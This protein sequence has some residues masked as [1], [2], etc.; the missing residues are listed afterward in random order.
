MSAVQSHLPTPTIVVGSRRVLVVDDDE[1]QLRAVER[2]SR[3][4]KQLEVSVADNAI[5]ALLRIGT[6]RPDIIVLDVFMPGLDGI[7]ACR[8]IKA[9]AATSSIEVVLAS[10]QW[11]S[12]LEAEAARAGATRVVTK[13]LDV[14]AFIGTCAREVADEA[15]PVAAPDPTVRGADLIVQMLADAGVEVVFGLPGGAISSVHDALLD[16]PLRVITTRH[17]NGAMFA[18]AG[19]A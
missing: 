5:D 8:R 3:G 10:A 16:S 1:L 9:N 6:L 19:Y 7:E 2:G 14:M 18:A 17:E 15:V 13:P 11:N 12:E 4:H